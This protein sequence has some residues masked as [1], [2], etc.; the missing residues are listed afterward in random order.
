MDQCETFGFRPPQGKTDVKNSFVALQDI[1]KFL[2][3]PD[4][5]C[6]GAIVSE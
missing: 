4:M 6:G 1:H 5:N 2:L 3:F